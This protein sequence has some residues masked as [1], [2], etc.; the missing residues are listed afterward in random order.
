MATR[1][2]ADLLPV[3]ENEDLYRSTPPPFGHD[4]LRYFGFDPK[5][6]NL[7]HGELINPI[8]ALCPEYVLRG[9]IWSRL[10]SHQTFSR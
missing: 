7:N 3:K 5:Y 10:P 1:S 9:S 6:V 2:F 4:I 8:C